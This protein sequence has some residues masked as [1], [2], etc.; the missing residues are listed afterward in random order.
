MSNKSG[1]AGPV[2]VAA[3]C[4]LVLVPL[5]Y[6]L[7]AGPVIGLMYRGY[8]SQSTTMTV[9]SPLAFVSDKFTPLKEGMNWYVDLFRPADEFEIQTD[10]NVI[11]QAVP[12]AGATTRQLPS[13]Y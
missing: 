9:Y 3:A 10:I 8:I 1:F 4:L 6:I 11:Y 7:S 13:V 12:P 2:T 5:L